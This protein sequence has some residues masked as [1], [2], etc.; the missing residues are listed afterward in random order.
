[1]RCD[2]RHQSLLKVSSIQHHVRE[3][4]AIAGEKGGRN[5]T[6]DTFVSEF[7]VNIINGIAPVIIYSDKIS[8]ILVLFDCSVDA[9]TFNRNDIVECRRVLDDIG[10]AGGYIEN[11]NGCSNSAIGINISVKSGYIKSGRSLGNQA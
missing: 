1:M 4:H 11:S 10:A 5:R 8:E 6:L 2:V 7:N 3:I 9:G